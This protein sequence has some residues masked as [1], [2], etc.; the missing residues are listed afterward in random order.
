MTNFPMVVDS[1]E[2]SG[3][4][5][6]WSSYGG[7]FRAKP[8]PPK[9]PGPSGRRSWSDNPLL[10]SSSRKSDVARRTPQARLRIPLLSPKKSEAVRN[11]RSEM[12]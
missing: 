7:F 9:R 11:F 12:F 2:L 5:N 3:Q 6:A 1:S 10:L 8:H 4:E